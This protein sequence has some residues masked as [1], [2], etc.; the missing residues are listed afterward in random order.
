MHALGG[1]DIVIV[2]PHGF[3]PKVYGGEGN[4]IA[5]VDGQYA[6]YQLDN[7]GGTT[8]VIRDGFATVRVKS[9]D[10]IEFSDV[11][12]NTSDGSISPK[13]GGTPPPDNGQHDIELIANVIET[14]EFGNRYNGQTDADGVITASFANT[15]GDARLSLKGFDV[16]FHNEIEVLLNGDRLGFLST[17]PNNGLNNGDSFSIAASEQVAGSNIIT[18]KQAIDPRLCLGLYRSAA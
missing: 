13:N 1:D 15:G 17:G 7:A 16:D 9:F 8:W 18:I 3:K 6:D 5:I 4:D 11:F 14:A 10:R 2:S 12:F